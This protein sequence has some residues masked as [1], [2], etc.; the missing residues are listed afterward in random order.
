MT[1]AISLKVNDGIVLAADSA[2]SI[3][4][5]DPNG[6]NIGVVKV[7]NHADKVFNLCKGQPIGAITWG[8]GSIGQ[9]S[10]ATLMKD[11]RE[12]LN[13]SYPDNESTIEQVAQ[14]LATF[15]FED[16][17][18]PEFKDWAAKPQLG[19]MVVGYSHGHDFA[20]E[21]KIDIV[22]GKLN[23][24]YQVHQEHE[25]GLTWNGETEAI[26]RIFM[27]F[28]NGLESALINMRID[29]E[30]ASKIQNGL[31]E[32]LTVPL[33]L[34]PM[35]IQDAIALAEFLVELTI[36]FSKFS[37]GAETVGGP[38]DVATITKHEDFK[39]VR[40]KHYFSQEL[41]PD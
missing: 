37:P 10:I 7:Y 33:V 18:N 5:K 11:F 27:G 14:K 21:W 32:R 4:G 17:Y 41:N 36:K 39:W 24:P 34:P 16:H 20:E 8:A 2:S 12:Q 31:R 22:D 9:A 1:I 15:M 35:P 6:Q 13:Q 26:S 28:G 40:R 29:L 25:S 3:I 23:G 38:I 19:F 30:Q